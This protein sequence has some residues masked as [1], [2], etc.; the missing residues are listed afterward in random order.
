M[1]KRGGEG[2]GYSRNCRNLDSVSFLKHSLLS[3]FTAIIQK[4]T[5][6]ED[7]YGFVSIARKAIRSVRPSPSPILS[8]SFVFEG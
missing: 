5:I 8:L 6:Y 3:M 7:S 2:E 1:E 4:L